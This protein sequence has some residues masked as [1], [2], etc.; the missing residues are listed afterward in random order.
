MADCWAEVAKIYTL[1]P[2]QALNGENACCGGG[3]WLKGQLEQRIES[4]CRLACNHP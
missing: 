2:E 4:V 1:N 3:V